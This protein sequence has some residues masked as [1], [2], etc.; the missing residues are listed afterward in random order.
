MTDTE[1]PTYM[2]GRN[3]TGRTIVTEISRTAADEGFIAFQRE[4]VNDVV[5]PYKKLD[6][7]VRVTEL[8]P[9]MI[10]D[11]T[12]GVGDAGRITLV[13]LVDRDER[14]VLMIAG[15]ELTYTT[16]SPHANRLE[17]MHSFACDF[18]GSTSSLVRL[19]LASLTLKSAWGNQVTYDA[20]ITKGGY[21]TPDDKGDHD[22]EAGTSKNI[23]EAEYVDPKTVEGDYGY[24]AN[25]GY[26]YSPPSQAGISGHDF[27]LH[28]EIVHY[29]LGREAA[30]TW[31]R[32]E[33]GL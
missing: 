12:N 17:L 26:P 7:P 21:Y 2:E 6:E 5:Y 24:A 3:Q 28:V 19:D 18:E 23:Y 32:K 4:T 25:Y 31:F 22:S 33:A 29:S 14:T 10:Q 11:P 15:A 16:S 13:R 20:W 1:T 27:P 9:L 30:E 8:A